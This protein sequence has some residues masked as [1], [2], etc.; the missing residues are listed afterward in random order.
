MLYSIY[1]QSTTQFSKSNQVQIQ[2][3]SKIY[4]FI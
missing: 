2:N 4:K 3:I 1:S